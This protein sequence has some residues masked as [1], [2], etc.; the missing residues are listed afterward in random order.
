MHWNIQIQWK[1]LA[2]AFKSIIKQC[3]P[4]LS[5]FTTFSHKIFHHHVFGVLLVRAN[6]HKP[7]HHDKVGHH[8]RG[9]L[10][11][12]DTTCRQHKQP[13]Q[14]TRMQF[15]PV[16]RR[17]LCMGSRTRVNAFGYCNNF[18]PDL[19]ARTL[20]EVPSGK[21]VNRYNL[22]TQPGCRSDCM[23][24]ERHD[25]HTT[26]HSPQGCRFKRA[27]MRETESSTHRPAQLLY[28]FAHNSS[29]STRAK[30]PRCKAHCVNT[31]A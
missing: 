16:T 22:T 20:S 25:V 13:D 11:K 9:S 1:Q 7:L 12:V 26:D 24:H 4:N 28:Q 15:R 19:A 21:T 31:I 18:A 14:G 2:N 27:C 23:G 5:Q 10:W 3:G 6:K 17:M 8:R 29:H 30:V